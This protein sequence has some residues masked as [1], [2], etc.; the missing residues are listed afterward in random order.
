MT[1]QRHGPRAGR[2]EAHLAL[3]SGVVYAGRCRSDLKGRRRHL[4]NGKATLLGNAL[5]NF[6]GALSLLRPPTSRRGPSANRI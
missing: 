5:W 2:H 4:L 3:V 1:P 6:L